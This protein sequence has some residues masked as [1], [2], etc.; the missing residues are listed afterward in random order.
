MIK[1]MMTSSKRL[2]TLLMLRVESCLQEME[3]KKLELERLVRQII[4]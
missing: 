4:R 2:V 1:L 3:L